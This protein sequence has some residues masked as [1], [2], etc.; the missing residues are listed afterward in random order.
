[1]EGKPSRYQRKL[2]SVYAVFFVLGLNMAFACPEIPAPLV[3]SMTHVEGRSLQGP[4]LPKCQIMLTK[5]NSTHTAVE[6]CPPDPLGS[7]L[8]LGSK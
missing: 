4:E 7:T 8:S 3:L 1:M 5:N 2:A 6:T